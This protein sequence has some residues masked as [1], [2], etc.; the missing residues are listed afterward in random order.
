MWFSNNSNAIILATTP[1]CVRVSLLSRIRL[2]VTPWTVA[3]QAPLT[4]KFSRQEYWSG[5]PCPPPGDL[6]NPG[7]EPGSLTLQANS[8]GLNHQGSPP[9]WQG[10]AI[11]LEGCFCLSLNKPNAS[12]THYTPCRF[13]YM[14]LERRAHHGHTCCHPSAGPSHMTG[15]S[16][17][18]EAFTTFSPT[19][20]PAS[21]VTRDTPSSV[22]WR[23]G[24]SRPGRGIQLRV[25]IQT[26]RTPYNQTS[27]K[28]GL[29]SKHFLF[30]T[31][32]EGSAVGFT[33]QR[34][35]DL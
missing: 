4:M 3:R 9:P 5:L 7:I 22:S 18:Y 29:Q 13:T 31:G 25:K 19:F 15:N 20:W 10:N 32:G 33:N 21:C 16:A 12:S 28:P 17:T 26:H 30:T 24:C 6:P 23:P 2:F 8:G 34:N 1:V 14:S 35:A 11:V 27:R